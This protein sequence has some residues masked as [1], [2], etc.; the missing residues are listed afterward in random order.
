MLV[1]VLGESPASGPALIVFQFCLESVWA[2]L[3]PICVALEPAAQLEP[4]AKSGQ[5][6]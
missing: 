5:S 2:R 4:A 6:A 1:R 3:L